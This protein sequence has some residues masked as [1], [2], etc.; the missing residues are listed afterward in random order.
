[1]HLK[2][3]QSRPRIWGVRFVA[4]L[5]W[6]KLDLMQILWLEGTSFLLKWTWHMREVHVSRNKTD[7]LFMPS[8]TCYG[9]TLPTTDMVRWLLSHSECLRISC[10][11]RVA[12]DMNITSWNCD[13]VLLCGCGLQH[14]HALGA[15]R[16]IEMF[17]PR[18]FLQTSVTWQCLH[19]SLQRSHHTC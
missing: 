13:M 4:P 2:L 7:V 6:Q 16:A 14:T 3:F 19:M 5:P 18:R 8:Q 17:E 1:M 9:M 15:K 11:T 12:A 10:S